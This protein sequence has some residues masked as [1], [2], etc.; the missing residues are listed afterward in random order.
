MS[1]NK[2]EARFTKKK[3]SLIHFCKTS[4]GNDTKDIAT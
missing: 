1:V 3:D 4:A 2:H